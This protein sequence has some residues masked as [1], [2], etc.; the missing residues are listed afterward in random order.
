MLAAEL[1]SKYTALRAADAFQLSVA[2]HN[3]AEIFLTADKKLKQIQEIDIF[4]L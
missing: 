3:E 1:R 2:I 4:V